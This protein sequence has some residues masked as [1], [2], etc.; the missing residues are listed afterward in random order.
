M[1][2][3]VPSI[4]GFADFERIGVGGFSVVYRAIQLD[5]GRPVAVKVLDVDGSDV[6]AR[7]RFERECRAI[8]ALSGVP[9]IVAI[10]Q[11]ALTD[12]GRLAIVMELMA[13]S[14]ESRVHAEGP[15]TVAS[16]CELGATL[17]G[18]LAEA[19][20]R[21]IAHRDLKPGNV[22]LSPRG[23]VALADFGIAMVA[24]VE[25]SSQT[26][27]S[28][29]PPYAAPERFGGGRVDERAADV[30]SLGATL[31]FALAGES[32]FGSVATE[33]G[34]LG[35]ISRITRDPLPSLGRPDVP[36]GL[37]VLLEAMTAK[38]PDERPPHAADLVDRF[39]ELADG[40]EA[41]PGSGG[42][43]ASGEH[44]S[45][46]LDA[47]W[48]SALPADDSAGRSDTPLPPEPAPDPSPPSTG[49]IGGD[50]DFRA[51]RAKVDRR[52]GRQPPPARPETASWWRDATP[53]LSENDRGSSDH[54]H[55]SGSDTSS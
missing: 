36:A 19:H 54:A 31:Y 23:D 33:G 49:T 1:R 11:S 55:P 15:L 14:L 44:A 16:A 51:R 13:G 47:W 30:Y 27:G 24:E 9:G 25:A 7:R 18:A 20:A 34:I 12:Q 37:V 10:H 29:S 4:D 42:D 46:N 50:A 41:G 38:V 52:L 45:T 6:A 53:G 39:R 28:L 26:E 35:L 5:L 3:V 2:E 8:G 43:D 32:P 48:S 21:S 40:S 17:A 22:L